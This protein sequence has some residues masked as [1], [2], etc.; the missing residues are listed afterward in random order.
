MTKRIEKLTSV[1]ISCC[2]VGPQQPGD[3]MYLVN[4]MYCSWKTMNTLQKSEPAVVTKE[5][6]ASYTALKVHKHLRAH[7]V[8]TAEDFQ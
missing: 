2:V 3:R 1:C 8:F 5:Q 4:A 6:D 7:T